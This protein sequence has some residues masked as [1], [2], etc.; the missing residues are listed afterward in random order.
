MAEVTLNNEE[1]EVL[2]INI[3]K[4][5]YSLPLGGDISYETLISLKTDSGMYAFLKEHIPEDVVKSLKVKEIRQIF[6]VWNEETK[7]ATGLMPGE[8]SASR[9]S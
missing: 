3:G 8:S 5:S 9:G 1:V 7:K 2:K 4:D 6:L